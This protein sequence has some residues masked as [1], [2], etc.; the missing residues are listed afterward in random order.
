MLGFG[1]DSNEVLEM[2]FSRSVVSM[3]TGN[4]D[5][6]ILALAKGEEYPQSHFHVKELINGS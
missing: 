5:E 3:I 6:A 4:H 2:L 1:P